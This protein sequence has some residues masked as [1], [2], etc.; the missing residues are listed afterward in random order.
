MVSPL[1][2]DW[3]TSC[4]LMLCCRGWWLRRLSW[5]QASNLSPT[6]PSLVS[7]IFPVTLLLP[8]EHPSGAVAS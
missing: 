7:Q 1:V 6:G 8:D 2:D 3:H 4:L 5:L